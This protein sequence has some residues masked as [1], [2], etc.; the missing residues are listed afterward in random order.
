MV[1]PTTESCT[2]GIKSDFF[3]LGRLSAKSQQGSLYSEVPPLSPL[4]WGEVPTVLSSAIVIEDLLYKNS[5]KK[6]KTCQDWGKREQTDLYDYRQR[7]R[8]E[9]CVTEIRQSCSGKQ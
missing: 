7:K 2:L 1:K 3:N 4:I 9:R 8:I 6:I 5:E